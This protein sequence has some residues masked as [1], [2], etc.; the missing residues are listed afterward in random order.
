MKTRSCILALGMSSEWHIAFAH[1]VVV[2]RALI[3]MALKTSINSTPPLRQAPDN[4]RPSENSPSGFSSPP[5][6]RS[7][8]GGATASKTASRSNGKSVLATP[9]YPKLFGKNLQ[10]PCEINDNLLTGKIK[11]GR[12]LLRPQ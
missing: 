4:A 5:G 9:F 2:H 10:K 12:T 1:D 8:E 11:R 3:C 7:V 6:T